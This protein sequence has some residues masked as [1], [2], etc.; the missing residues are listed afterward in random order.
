MSLSLDSQQQWVF[1]KQGSLG[2]RDGKESRHLC[3]RSDNGGIPFL[4]KTKILGCKWM[5]SGGVVTREDFR[6][7]LVIT[8]D[9]NS[10][11]GRKLARPPLPSQLFIYVNG[12]LVNPSTGL[13]LTGA[14][15]RVQLEKPREG[16]KPQVV[17]LMNEQWYFIGGRVV[18]AWNGLVLTRKQGDNRLYILPPDQTDK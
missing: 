13:L 8:A 3:Q 12:T 15:N 2:L 18:S 5:L 6:E 9:T 11:R 17:H 16:V 4:T 10:V 7:K 14:S 1:G